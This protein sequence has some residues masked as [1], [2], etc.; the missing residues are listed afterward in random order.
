MRNGYWKKWM[1]TSTLYGRYFLSSILQQV[2][3]SSESY[4]VRQFCP[5]S[6]C[7]TTGHIHRY[8][9][10]LSYH[11]VFSSW[12]TNF[13]NHLI[14]LSFCCFLLMCTFIFVILIVWLSYHVFLFFIMTLT[15]IFFWSFTKWVVRILLCWYK[16]ILY[17]ITE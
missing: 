12:I 16:Q 9:D 17:Y 4:S 15:Y 5:S 13:C 14:V 8:N 1:K 2:F 7:F 6:E 11:F 3:D 10:R